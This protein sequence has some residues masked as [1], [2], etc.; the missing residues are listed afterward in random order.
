MP[1]KTVYLYSD[2][3]GNLTKRD[4]KLRY[5]SSVFGFAWSFLNPLSFMLVMSIVFG[6][7][8]PSGIPNYPVFLLCGLLPWRF[9][10]VA[11]T[12]SLNS[13]VGNSSLVSKI[14]FPRQLLVLSTTLANLMGTIIE[15]SILFTLMLVFGVTIRPAALLFIPLLAYEFLFA[16]GVSLALSALFVFYR[17][18]VHLWDVFLN[19]AMWSVPVVYSLTQVPHRFLTYYLLNPMV[20]M[21]TTFRDILLYGNLPGFLRLTQMLVALIAVWGTGLIVFRHYEPRFADEVA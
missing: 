17:D 4:F 21:I 14:Y 3:V 6:Y 11:T 10:Q 13:I 7:I 16:Y 1:L 12:Q 5:R 15:F 20:P 19:L 2:L 18:L 8:F 9:F